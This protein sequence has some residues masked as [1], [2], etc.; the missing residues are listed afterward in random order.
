LDDGPEADAWLELM[1]RCG[2]IDGLV[3]FFYDSLSRMMC[4]G[5]EFFNLQHGMYDSYEVRTS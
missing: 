3:A 1:E 5:E 2:A 4:R